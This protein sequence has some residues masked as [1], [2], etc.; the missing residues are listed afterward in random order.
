MGEVGSS[1]IPFVLKGDR[2]GPLT[3]ILL[4]SP[5]RKL[6]SPLP[7]YALPCC[8]LSGL[9]VASGLSIIG[10]DV[11]SYSCLCSRANILLFFTREAR[12]RF[13]IDDRFAGDGEPSRSLRGFR[14]SALDLVGDA[15]SRFCQYRRGEL[16]ATGDE[17]K[18]D[19]SPLKKFFFT[20]FS[21][22]V[23]LIWQSSHLNVLIEAWRVASPFH[24][25]Q[26]SERPLCRWSTRLIGRR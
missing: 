13:S 3:G 24:R 22:S 6:P 19:E 26:L 5:W 2:S 25:P 21:G 10:L 11:G 15:G 8:T 1:G 18:G 23:I 14:F 7:P 16:E 4:L 20:E 9:P 17:S 12:L